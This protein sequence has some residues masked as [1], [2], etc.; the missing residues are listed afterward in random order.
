VITDESLKHKVRTQ[1]AKYTALTTDNLAEVLLKVIEFTHA[2]Q[3]ILALNIRSADKPGFTPKD[4]PCSEFADVLNVAINEHV[5]TN[6]L[7]LADTDNIKFLA[8]GCFEVKPVADNHAKHLL[9]TSK[10]QYIQLQ[11]EKVVENALNQQFA[12]QLLWGKRQLPAN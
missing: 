2:R 7:L 5:Q 12:A 11:V 10:E 6:R 4:L 9:R 3:K 8:G 1:A